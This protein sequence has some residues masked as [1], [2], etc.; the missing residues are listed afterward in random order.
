MTQLT[1]KRIALGFVLW[2]VLVFSISRSL[3]NSIVYQKKLDAFKQ[4]VVNQ[5]LVRLGSQKNSKTITPFK[6]YQWFRES[7][8]KITFF[9]D[10]EAKLTKLNTPANTWSVSLTK[11]DPDTEIVTFVPV[12]HSEYYF[13]GNI[14][15]TYQE[16]KTFGETVY[17]IY[18]SRTDYSLV[19]VARDGVRGI[20]ITVP[21]PLFRKA[22]KPKYIDLAQ[23]KF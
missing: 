10:R 17:D 2:I 7:K 1:Y 21:D 19:F 11:N 6:R 13:E 3:E 14:L 5:D 9:Y 16:R 23:T 4:E 20:V 18:R 8:T 22:K 15:Y 12:M